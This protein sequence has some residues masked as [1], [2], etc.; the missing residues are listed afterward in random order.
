MEQVL[1]LARYSR[2]L[3]ATASAA[4]DL[5]DLH[6]ELRSL[7]KG[8]AWTLETD[9]PIRQTKEW[10]ADMLRRLKLQDPVKMI[11]A[12]NEDVL[13]VYDCTE[14]G[15]DEFTPNRASISLYW[16]VIGSVA[17]MDGY[18]VED[19]TVVVLAHELAHAYTQ[20][21]ADTDGRRWRAELF[22]QAEPALV[23]GLAQYYT[24]RTLLRTAWSLPRRARSVLAPADEAVCPVPCS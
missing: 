23:E 4:G 2:Q 22:R 12:F 20:L 15:R 19:L 11:L 3:A 8:A 10:A 1:L 6:H 13:G 18:T 17:H 24:E 9:A 21:G 5:L 7:P 14:S 16:G